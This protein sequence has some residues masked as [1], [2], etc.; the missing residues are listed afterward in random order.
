MRWQAARSRGDVGRAGDDERG[1]VTT[2]MLAVIAVVLVLGL[3]LAGLSRAA[4]AHATAQASADLAALAAAR[5]V[6]TPGG[7]DPCATAARVAQRHETELVAC[8]VHGGGM[9]QVRMD[10]A[11]SPWAGWPARAGAVARAGPVGHG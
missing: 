5:V 11:I 2:V 9:V 8:S 3:G 1:S 6:S 4:H 10:R 7:G